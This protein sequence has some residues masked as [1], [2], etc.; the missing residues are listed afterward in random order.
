M[1]DILCLTSGLTGILYAS[2]ELVR[3][4]SAAGHRLTYASFPEA[5]ETVVGHGVRFLPLAPSRYSDFLEA[6]S[7]RGIL[8]RL[9][10]VR[11]RREQA[12]VALAVDG[13]SGV[14]RT[15][16]PQLILI[17][18]EMHAHIIAASA[19]GVPIVLLNSFASLW[20]LPGLPPTHHLVRPGVGWKGSRAGIWMLWRN[21]R[22]RKLRA[23]LWQKWR[24]LGCDRLSILREL[25]SQVGFDFQRETDFDQWPIPFTYRS[26][27]VLSLHAREFEFPHEPREG[28]HY[29]GPMILAQ[30]VDRA[31]SRRDRAM[32]E[33]LFERRRSS[34]AGRK[35]IYAGFGSSFSSDRGLLQR[36]VEA[37]SEREEWDLLIS[38]G[39][40]VGPSEL[41]VLPAN[42]RAF[43]WLPQPTVLQHADAVVTHGGINTIDESVVYGVPMLIYCGFETDMGGNTA[44]VVHHGIGIAGDSR[45]DDPRTM[46]RHLDRLLTEAQFKDSL[47][48]LRSCYL[49]YAENHVAER[50]IDALLAD[51]SQRPARTE[52]IS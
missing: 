48:R 21:L 15:I 8:D 26:L 52:D 5:Q 1:A 31:L 30:R 40:R 44:R 18:G 11:H 19:T 23:A 14:I 29:V 27:P 47:A 39:G 50:I 37:V 35:L 22:L 42:V 13:L 4:L 3:R 25:A 6:D 20:N 28:V 24:S 33:S 2:L 43:S 46:R 10:T 45:R 9:R 34:S 7:E 49:A 17:D 12:V 38:L 51:S 36:L 41:G 16:A 32:L